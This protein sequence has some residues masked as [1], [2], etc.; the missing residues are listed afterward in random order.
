MPNE[1]MRSKNGK[2]R[3]VVLTNGERYAATVLRIETQDA[4]GR[5][6]TLTAFYDDDSVKTRS[7]DAFLVVYAKEECVESKSKGDA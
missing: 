4:L 3:T 5:P 7:G 1:A 2:A 6:K